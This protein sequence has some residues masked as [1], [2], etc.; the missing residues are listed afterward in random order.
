LS[1]FSGPAGRSVRGGEPAETVP[2][3]DDGFGPGPGSLDL[4]GAAAGVADEPGGD[5]QDRG[6]QGLRLGGGEVIAYSG[7]T[8]MGSAVLSELVAALL[9]V[10]M[11]VPVLGGVFAV[12]GMLAA[13]GGAEL[14]NRERG[15]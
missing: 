3:G 1:S 14:D 5:V 7:V 12:V 11:L 10:P 13:I 9:S 2:G 8:L 6:A 4:Q 15:A